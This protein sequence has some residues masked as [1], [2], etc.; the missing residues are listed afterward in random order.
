MI[1]G[2]RSAEL[3]SLYN[4][5]KG[6]GDFALA[7]IPNGVVPAGRSAQLTNRLIDLGLA[8][9]T[10]GAASGGPKFRAVYHPRPT[11]RMLQG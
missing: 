7:D 9:I 8:K 5:A 11:L 3:N 10:A 6:R 1:R 4:W 2:S